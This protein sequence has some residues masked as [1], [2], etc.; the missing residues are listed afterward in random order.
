[1]KKFFQYSF[2]IILLTFISLLFTEMIQK[3]KVHVLQYVLIGA[4]MIIYYCLLLSFSEQV[5]FNYAYLIASVSTIVL[6]SLFIASI[7]KN[8][9]T[10]LLFASILSVFYSLIFI[11]IQ[12]QDL[13]LLYASIGLFIIV[14]ALMYLSSKIY[15][16]KKQFVE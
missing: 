15:W 7:L 16:S 2:L 12:L 4:A 5:G 1:M 14:A 3:K 13:A 11:I 9:K 6:V 8:K 10:A